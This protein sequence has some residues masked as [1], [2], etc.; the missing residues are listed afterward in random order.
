[1]LE[2]NCISASLETRASGRR[3]GEFDHPRI[4]FVVRD[5]GGW[6]GG[7]DYMG[8]STRIAAA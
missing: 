1:M 5:Q 3:M 6:G 4:R 7:E 8:G 2:L